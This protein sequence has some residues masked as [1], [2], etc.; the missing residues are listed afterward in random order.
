MNLHSLRAL[1]IFSREEDRFTHRIVRRQESPNGAVGLCGLAGTSLEEWPR[2]PPIQQLVLEQV[3][4]PPRTVALGVG[5]SGAGHWSLATEVIRAGGESPVAPIA[6]DPTVSDLGIQM[7]WACRIH[8]PAE[9][10]GCSYRALG[11]M[12]RIAHA[13]T[14]NRAEWLLA[15]DARFILTVTEGQIVWNEQESIVSIVPV[16]DI[17][18]T[19]THTWRYCLD[20]V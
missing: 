13:W 19:G 7:D 9:R 17:R 20:V 6:V 18:R 12:K 1:A 2:D 5:M 14:S 3:G 10:L 4:S 11:P 8:R 16:S 15:E